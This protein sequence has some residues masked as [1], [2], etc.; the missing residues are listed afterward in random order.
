[1]PEVTLVRTSYQ[2]SEASIFSIRNQVFV[3]EQSVPLEIEIDEFDPVARHVLVYVDHIDGHRIPVGTGR[4]TADG[5]IGR[6]AVLK[7]FRGQG[8]GAVILEGL[9]RI[10]AEDG[11]DQACL[12]SQCQAIPF[13]ERFGFIAEGPVYQE[14]DIDH[15]WMKRSLSRE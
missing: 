8:L 6:M 13:Y 7:S 3:I 4:I 5:K 10:A 14:A 1:M 15:R 2:E 9:V 11:L 12:S